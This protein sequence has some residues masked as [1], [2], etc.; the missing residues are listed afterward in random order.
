M[1]LLNI[2]IP[3]ATVNLKKLSCTVTI[4]CVIKMMKYGFGDESQVYT[5]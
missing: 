4:G 3:S 2:E 1:L 5:A